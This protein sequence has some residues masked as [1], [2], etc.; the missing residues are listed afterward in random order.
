MMKTG[1]ENGDCAL[2][3]LKT[4]SDL[5]SMLFN[6]VFNNLSEVDVKSSM[7]YNCTLIKCSWHD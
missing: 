5:F 2:V 6:S 1:F 4:L 3:F 7:S